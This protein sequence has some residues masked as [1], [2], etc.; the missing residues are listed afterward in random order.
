MPP[1]CSALRPR[2]RCPPAAA[3][4][5]PSCSGRRCIAAMPRAG[6]SMPCGAHATERSHE[7][8]GQVVRVGCLR[9]GADHRSAAPR[10]AVP[11]STE[12]HR[13]S[14]CAHAD[15]LGTCVATTRGRVTGSRQARWSC[16]AWR[17]AAI[18][19]VG[20]LP[21]RTVSRHAHGPPCC[22]TNPGVF[23]TGH[24]AALSERPRVQRLFAALCN[25]AILQDIIL[26]N[27]N[28]YIK[29]PLLKHRP[30]HLCYDGVVHAYGGRAPGREGTGWT[31]SRWWIRRSRCCASGAA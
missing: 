8:Q 24:T 5:S 14:G 16:A 29:T 13:L 26:K 23:H 6:G 9:L 4:C 15:V 17:E 28:A 22:A 30:R 11:R 20:M 27:S 3:R 19:G 2:A 1:S 21:M 25:S 18:T 10:R 31:L 12:D 7:H